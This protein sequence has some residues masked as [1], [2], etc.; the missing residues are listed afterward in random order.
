M[1]RVLED[2]LL[3]QL[4]DMAISRL[5]QEAVGLILPNDQV[6]ELINLSDY[7]LSSFAI[8]GKNLSNAIIEHGWPLTYETLKQTTIWHSHPNGGIGPSIR[9]LRA[10][11]TPF[12]FLVVTLSDGDL[13]PTWY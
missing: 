3:G 5:P 13:I 2:K 7:P 6:V 1:Y 4:R 10:K 8:Q 12:S 9:D 11:V